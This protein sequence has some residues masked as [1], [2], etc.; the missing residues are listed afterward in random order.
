MSC[1]GSLCLR[2]NW[3]LGFDYKCMGYITTSETC[4]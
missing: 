3:L 4:K 1:F 2:A